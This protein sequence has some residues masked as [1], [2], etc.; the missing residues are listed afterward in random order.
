MFFPRADIAQMSGLEGIRLLPF[1]YSSNGSAAD[2]A[3]FGGGSER[4]I[5]AAARQ[6]DKKKPESPNQAEE[7]LTDFIHRSPT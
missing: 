5:A 1:H 2:L 7:K 6:I 4:R 3:C